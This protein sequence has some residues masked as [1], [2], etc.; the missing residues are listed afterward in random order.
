V[1]MCMRVCVCMCVCV[2]VRVCVCLCVCAY[3]LVCGGVCPVYVSDHIKALL[4]TAEK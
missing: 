1:H 2:C 4:T 3:P